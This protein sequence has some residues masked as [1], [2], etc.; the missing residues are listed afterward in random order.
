MM[1]KP[2]P[3]LVDFESRLA[4]MEEKLNLLAAKVEA[5]AKVVAEHLDAPLTLPEQSKK[6]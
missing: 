2:G 1:M 5:L 3:Y 6:E 4:A